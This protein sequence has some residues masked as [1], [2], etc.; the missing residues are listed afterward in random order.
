MNLHFE[1]KRPRLEE[2]KDSPANSNGRQHLLAERKNDKMM[3]MQAELPKLTNGFSFA[4]QINPQGI[5]RA[6]HVAA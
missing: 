1:L 3:A 6:E 5:P 4:P 2:N